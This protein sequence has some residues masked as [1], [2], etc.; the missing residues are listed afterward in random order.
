MRR[1]LSAV[2]ECLMLIPDY[3]RVEGS[4]AMKKFK[5]ILQIGIAIGLAVF[6]VIGWEF[7]GDF[8]VTLKFL[9]GVPLF[10]ARLLIGLAAVGFIV[11]GV[12][13]FGAQP[14]ESEPTIQITD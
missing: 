14:V 2:N 1:V 10:G 12:S 9:P 6:L 8:Y 7:L 4:A 11:S 3:L 13:D 5:G